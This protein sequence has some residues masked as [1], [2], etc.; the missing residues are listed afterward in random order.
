MR[1]FMQNWQRYG[2]NSEHPLLISLQALKAGHFMAWVQILRSFLHF[3]TTQMCCCQLSL[4]FST[5]SDTKRGYKTHFCSNISQLTPKNALK[6]QQNG[7]NV[8]Y[9]LHSFSMFIK[10][11][12][13][14]WQTSFVPFRESQSFIEILSKC[15]RNELKFGPMT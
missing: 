6:V 13:V 10:Q 8:V 14:K 2:K 1:N 3:Q 12:H 5:F 7:C 9:I 4:V 11:Y 15:N